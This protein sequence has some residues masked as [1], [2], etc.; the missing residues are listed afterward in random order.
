MQRRGNIEGTWTCGFESRTKILMGHL[1]LNVLSMVGIKTASRGHDRYTLGVHRR[2]SVWG[3]PEVG[4]R[5]CK[6]A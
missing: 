3:T 4:S 5:A 1:L 6:L 2:V